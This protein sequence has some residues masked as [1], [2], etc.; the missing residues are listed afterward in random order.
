MRADIS[1]GILAAVMMIG[2][3]ACGGPSQVI[4]GTVVSFAPDTKTLVVKDELPPNAEVSFSLEKADVG[5]APEVGNKVRLSYHTE[6][7]RLMAVRVMD[8]SHGVEGGT[9]GH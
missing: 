3:S 7:K 2:L 9:K 8:L 5:R 6:G 1:A 4:Q